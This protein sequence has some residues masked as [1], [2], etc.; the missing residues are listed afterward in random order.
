MSW[1]DL[2]WICL[3]LL[4]NLYQQLFQRFKELAVHSSQE[5]QKNIKYCFDD[6][7]SVQ[8]LSHAFTCLT[9]VSM[10]VLK[11]PSHALERVKI[12]IFCTRAKKKIKLREMAIFINT[13]IEIILNLIKLFSIKPFCLSIMQLSFLIYNIFSLNQA[14]GYT[15]IFYSFINSQFHCT[16]SSFKADSASCSFNIACKAFDISRLSMF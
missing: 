5:Y 2:L 16:I 9:F 6:L 14:Y 13:N 1:V 8:T 3:F 10:V 7:R 15:Q 11:P 4:R 12:Q